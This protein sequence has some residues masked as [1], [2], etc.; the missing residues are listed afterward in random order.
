LVRPSI[1]LNQTRKFLA[2]A[3][4]YDTEKQHR[5]TTAQATTALNAHNQGELTNASQCLNDNVKARHYRKDGKQ[6][7]VTDEGRTGLDK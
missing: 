5:L 2:T 6:F 1:F 7:Y 3:F 4:G